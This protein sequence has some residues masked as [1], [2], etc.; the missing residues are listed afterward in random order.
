MTSSSTVER[1]QVTENNHT[2]NKIALFS[3]QQQQTNNLQ[4]TR[5]KNTAMMV[6]ALTLISH[7]LVRAFFVSNFYYPAFLHANASNADDAVAADGGGGNIIQPQPQ[8][9]LTADERDILY[10]INKANASKANASKPF[11]ADIHNYRKQKQQKHRGHHEQTISK[12]SHSIQNEMNQLSNMNSQIGKHSAEIIQ[13]KDE[14][15]TLYHQVID[16]AEE[17]ILNDIVHFNLE[18]LKALNERFAKSLE[19][20]LER[21][22]MEAEIR[23][24]PEESDDELDDGDDGDDDDDI[25][26]DIDRDEDRHLKNKITK[27]ELKSILTDTLDEIIK[28]TEGDLYDEIDKQLSNYIETKIIPHHVQQFDHKVKQKAVEL[29]ETRENVKSIVEKFNAKKMNKR[30]A[31]KVDALNMV[32]SSLWKFDNDGGMIDHLSNENGRGASIVYGEEWTSR[33]YTPPTLSTKTEVKSAVPSKSKKITLKDYHRYIPEDWERVLPDGW[34]DLDVTPLYEFFT[35]DPRLHLPTSL[36]HSLP[37]PLAKLISPLGS[38]VITKS[39][40][41]IMDRNNNLGSCWAMA[42][43]SGKVTVRLDR[44]VVVQSITIDHHPG[45]TV[46]GSSISAPRLMRAVGYPPCKD[47]DEDSFDCIKYGFDTSEHVELASFEYTPVPP[48][49]NVNSASF[50]DLSEDGMVGDENYPTRST[51]TFA[52]GSGSLI[53]NNGKEAA[54]EEEGGEKAT[55]GEENDM[56]GGSCSAAKP[57]CGAEVLDDYDLS[58][59]VEVPPVAAVSIIVDENWGHKYFTCIYRVRIHGD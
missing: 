22:K 55:G 38:P 25:D 43:S 56:F 13:N 59:S 1:L 4:K 27:S 16:D 31:T 45:I 33:T 36:W 49:L 24:I 10:Q 54:E 23:F 53:A 2:V 40:E 19:E 32:Q 9:D 58:Q 8:L 21:R 6:S 44:P 35:T 46:N 51:Q 52:V 48:P 29:G 34:E 18:Q 57:S 30:C 41:T 11:N 37:G 17:L 47:E 7:L 39:P 3:Q 14:I 20:E 26:I 50:G 15:E 5:G 12:V 42:G 28:K